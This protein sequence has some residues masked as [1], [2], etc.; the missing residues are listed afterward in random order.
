MPL[1]GAH[2]LSDA[3]NRSVAELEV[4]LEDTLRQC[5]ASLP[6]SPAGDG[7][8]AIPSLIAVWLLSQVG[9]AIATKRPVNLSKVA[10]LNDL[11]SVGG[12]AR[13]LHHALHPAPAVAL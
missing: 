10:D 4:D 5:K 9:K 6:A 3:R 2:P 8:R 1:P 11:R 7:T 12:V 13:L